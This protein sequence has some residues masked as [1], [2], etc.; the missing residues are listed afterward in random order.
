MWRF[1]GHKLTLILAANHALAEQ[2]ILHRDISEGNVMVDLVE[3]RGL[4]IDLDM[5]E[6]LRQQAASKFE[7]SIARIFPV[8]VGANQPTETVSGALGPSISNTVLTQDT[9]EQDASVEPSQNPGVH[10]PITVCSCH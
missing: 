5:A 7:A 2:D 6:D 3:N 1:F 9:P 10:D 4:L 8:R